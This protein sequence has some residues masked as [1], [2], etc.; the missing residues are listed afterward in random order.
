MI[1]NQQT[2]L[3]LQFDSVILNLPEI[4]L[5]TK[6]YLTMGTDAGALKKFVNRVYS[7][8]T[9]EGI[10]KETVGSNTFYYDQEKLIKVEEYMTESS[11]TLYA[12]WYYADDKPLYYTPQSDKAEERANFL[13]TLSKSMLEQFKK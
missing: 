6:T 3:K 4:G 10:K 13:L 8:S 2:D 7:I 5:N 9:L 12:D 11:K 1:I